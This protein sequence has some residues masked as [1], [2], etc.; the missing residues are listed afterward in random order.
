MVRKVIGTFYLVMAAGGLFA[1]VTQQGADA[2]ASGVIAAVFG[3]VGLWLLLKKGKT[4]RQKVADKVEKAEAVDSYIDAGNTIF[5]TDGVP[6]SDREIPYLIE[7]GLQK[8]MDY[9]TNSPNPKFHRTDREHELMSQFFMRYGALSQKKTDEFEALDRQ[10]YQTEDLDEKIVLLQAA[11]Q[12]Y[13]EAKTW[14]YNKS[15]GAMLWFQDMWEYMHSSRNP[16]FSWDE[17]VQGYLQD[18]IYERDVVRPKILNAAKDGVLQKDLYSS[19]PPEKKSVVREC[20]KR[21][22]AAGVISKTKKGNT[23]LIQSV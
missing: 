6:I 14:H 17:N 5:R 16:C 2:V 8:A 3:V 9:K 15:K 18:L 12:K 21:L 7:N 4:N 20:M 22:E 23:Y 11:L 13:E 1:A 10:A 19:F